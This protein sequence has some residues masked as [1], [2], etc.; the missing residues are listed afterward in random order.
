MAFFDNVVNKLTSS[1]QTVV[2]KTKDLTELTKLTAQVNDAEKKI[3][4]LYYKLG[5]EVYKA[6]REEPLEAGAEY[7]AQITELHQQI[8]ALKA[9]MPTLNSAAVCPKCGAKV[10]KDMVFCSGCG[11]KLN[12]EPA[13]VQA[14][15]AGKVC[16]KCGAPL[17]EGMLFCMSCGNK[18]E[19]Q[20]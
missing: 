4:D 13:P 8:A 7:F 3:N 20:A 2:Q 14:P 12:G 10:S 6:H 5:F 1:S 18:V 15:V 9:Q 16:S 19:E 11:Y 17:S